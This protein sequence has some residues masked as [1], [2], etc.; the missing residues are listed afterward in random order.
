MAEDF[1][2][3]DVSRKF[4]YSG[5]VLYWEV[6]LIGSKLLKMLLTAITIILFALIL[7]NR[8]TTRV[9]RTSA[10]IIQSEFSILSEHQ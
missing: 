7:R 10:S 6:H 8:Q 5:S 1:S 3:S 2:R 9:H 4:I